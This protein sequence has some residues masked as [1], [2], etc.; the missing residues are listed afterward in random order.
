[1][2]ECDN[3][4]ADE[5]SMRFFDV[6]GR[7]QKVMFRQTVIRAM[8]KRGLDGG[9][10]NDKVDKKLVHLTLAGPN[11][12][13]DE[14]IQVLASG[15]PINDWG[16]QVKSISELDAAHGKPIDKHQVTTQNVDSHKWNPNVVMYI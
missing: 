12:S 3:N 9:A 16:A 1:M 6:R 7:V 8:I 15:K 10:S 4:D 5:H 14:L 13:I 2:A 11:E